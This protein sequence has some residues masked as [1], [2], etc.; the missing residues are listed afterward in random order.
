M[1]KIEI[2]FAEVGERPEQQDSSPQLFGEGLGLADLDVRAVEG[3]VVEPQVEALAVLFTSLR[4]LYE[5]R[6]CHTSN[7]YAPKSISVPTDN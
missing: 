7:S 3:R 5:I 1:F 6:R 2:A 4:R